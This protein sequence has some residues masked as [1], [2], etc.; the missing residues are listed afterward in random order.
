VD[1]DE[2]AR[3]LDDLHRD[4]K[5]D[6]SEVK[7]ALLPREVYEARHTALVH[8]VGQL[9]LRHDQDVKD[10]RADIDRDR[11]A[12]RADRKWLISALIVPVVLFIGQLVMNAQGVAG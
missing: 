5:D 9:E 6:F 8:R 11:E 12:R 3:R 7:A 1:N 2:L 10:L 4:W